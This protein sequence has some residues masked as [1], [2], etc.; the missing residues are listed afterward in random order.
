ML[1]VLTGALL[2]SSSA[3]SSRA[4]RGALRGRR[5]ARGR[6]ASHVDDLLDARRQ[7]RLIKKELEGRVEHALATGSW[8]RTL[9]SCVRRSAARRRR[10]RALPVRDRR[11][12]E[13]ASR[14][15]RAPWS[16]S[17]GAVM[18]GLPL[19]PRLVAARPAEV[20]H[21]HERSACSRSPGGCLPRDCMSSPRQASSRRA[22]C[23]SSAAF[24]ALGGSDALLLPATA[25]RDRRGLG[26]G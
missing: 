13:P 12:L 21:G 10:D 7:A 18:L 14:P 2:S 4:V 6:C 11:G 15:A 22:S 25:R 9:P 1:S 23:S 20:L 8:V 19:L 26:V 16:G 3:P 24:A 17:T 5:D